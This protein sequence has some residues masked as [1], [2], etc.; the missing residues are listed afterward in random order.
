MI[1]LV[2]E[3]KSKLYTG[4]LVSLIIAIIA[5]FIG[6]A[7]PVVGGS[8]IALAIGILF[9][10]IM[11]NR[12]QMDDGVKFVSK[13]VLQL[14]IILLGSRMKINQVFSIGKFSAFVMLFTVSSAFLSSYFFGRLMNINNRLKGLI[15]AGTAICGGSA[16]LA[17]S[18]IIEAD[19]SDI[20][21]AISAIFLFDVIM[22]VLF[23]FMGLILGLSDLSYGLW[24]GTAINDTS[25]VVAAGYAFSNAAGNYATIVKLTRTTAIIPVTL[26]YS[27]ITVYKAK[28]SGNNSK[29]SSMS[30]VFPWFIV[31]FLASSIINSMGLINP[32]VN[33]I[34]GNL[35]KFM[36]VMALGAVG[37]KTDL[38]K[39]MN[40]GTKPILLGF[41]V[42]S[43]VVIVSITVQYFSG[44]N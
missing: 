17:L 9:N 36:M 32:E 42:S 14:A 22:I 12:I 37:L 15:G 39:M 16:I 30:S 10:Y 24:A 5:T 31:L 3:N 4:F 11:E 1:C 25:S 33:T 7:V 28:K 13:R 26:I 34:L 19:E 40:S 29:K 18:P 27:A 8:I 44:I 21:Y 43:I 41:I 35:S 2:Y 20:A 38:R 6:K 23:P